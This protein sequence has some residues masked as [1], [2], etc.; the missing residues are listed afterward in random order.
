M[1][2]KMASVSNAMPMPSFH[3][4]PV[5]KTNVPNNTAPNPAATPPLRLPDIVLPRRNN[6][7][8]VSIEITAFTIWAHWNEVNPSD[9]DMKESNRFRPG[10]AALCEVP[11]ALSPRP[12]RWPL[13]RSRDAMVHSVRPSLLNG[14][15]LMARGSSLVRNAAT[16]RTANA[17][18]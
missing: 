10:V 2:Q 4:E 14:Y 17:M 12:M 7:D 13:P 1:K 6:P 18:T 11:D 8:T 3:T 9:P 16:E 15:G 5:V